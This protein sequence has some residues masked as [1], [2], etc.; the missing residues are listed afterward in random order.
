MF[1]GIIQ[2]IGS[3]VALDRQGDWRMTVATKL[4][5]ADV[6]LGASIAC[7]G[8]C[9]TVIE[10]TDQAFTVQISAETR[11][12]TTAQNWGVGTRLNLERALR[13]GDELG[14]HIVAGHVDALAHVVDLKADGESVRFGFEIPETLAKFVAPKGSVTL[15]GVSLTVNEVHGSRFGVNIIPHTQ[16]MTTL[17][18]L[19][20]GDVVNFE[21]DLIARY[22]ERMI[23]GVK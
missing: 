21:V 3:V 12:K 14:G 5:L 2:D 11:A 23:G 9:L 16:K 1:S 18:D 10:K 22:V 15:E 13:M 6:G 17:G 19:K 8:V 7:S 20:T 4:P